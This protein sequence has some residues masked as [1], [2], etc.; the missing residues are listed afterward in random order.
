VVKVYKDGQTVY[1]S[2]RQI[3][4]DTK[5]FKIPSYLSNGRYTLGLK[6]SN[7]YGFWST[8]TTFVFTIETVSPEKPSMAFGINDMYVALL[9]SSTTQSNLIYR[10]GEKDTCFILIGSPELNAYMDY[11][12]PA[13]ESKY[14][15]RSVTDDSFCDSDIYTI[16][17][18]FEG[19]ILSDKSNPKDFIRLFRTKDSDKRK[20][21]SPTREKYLIKCSG[22]KYPIQQ[23]TEFYNHS[24]NHEYFIYQDEFDQFYRII[25]SD[26]L[27]YRNAYGYSF[28]ASASVT[29][30]QEDTFGYD[31]SFTLTRLEE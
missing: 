15:V 9:V 21:I 7:Q 3:G 5:E 19:I 29:T 22:R 1:N 17:M 4:K 23:I 20:S 26:T 6:V 14:Y 30:I 31:V 27:L 25:N 8:E 18:S 28:T 2:D 16:E 11:S 12:I 10:K 24:E 13:G